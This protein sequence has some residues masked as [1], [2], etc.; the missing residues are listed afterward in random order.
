M[1]SPGFS[2]KKAVACHPRS[3]PSSQTPSVLFKLLFLPCQ[4]NV[5]VSNSRDLMRNYQDNL[6]ELLRQLCCLQT[7]KAPYDSP[8]SNG[9]L[10][11]LLLSSYRST[12]SPNV[13]PYRLCFLS[14]VYAFSFFSIGSFPQLTNIFNTLLPPAKMC[15]P[16]GLLGKM[17][18]VNVAW[19]DHI[20]LRCQDFGS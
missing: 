5:F 15:L 6:T 4:K 2:A 14:A 9:A 18:K 20:S 19:Y 17:A 11:L 7:H 10:L 1:L 8:V 12:N 16:S 3:V 13:K